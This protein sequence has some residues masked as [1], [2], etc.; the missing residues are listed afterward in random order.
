MRVNADPERFGFVVLH[1][2]AAKE[3][4]Q[5]VDSIRCNC[6]G[7]PIVIVDNASHNGSFETVVRSYEHIDNV[8][9]LSNDRNYGFAMGN[10]VGYHYCRQTLDCGYIAICNNDLIVNDADFVE[11]C[12]LDYE[13]YRCGVIGPSIVSLRDGHEQNPAVGLLSSRRQVVKRI[14]RYRCELL[15][16]YLCWGHKQNQE[17]NSINVDANHNAGHVRTIDK[18][19]GAC[20]VFT[21]PF[22]EHFDDAFDPRTFLYVEEDILAIR[23]LRAG[24]SML[25]DPRIRVSH[26][27][28]V[29]TEQM[30]DN[31]IK[32]KRFVLREN[33]KSLH[34]LNQYFK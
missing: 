6:P 28:D 2:L 16:T 30:M 11:K 15:L 14:L 32:K 24:L 3:T 1:Y 4:M 17:V 10:N 27:E 12:R 5:C 26:E 29:S 7:C 31:G 9:L 18:L 19:H 21:P 33:I 25:F 23:C 22:I 13:T 8:Y 34:I 20:L